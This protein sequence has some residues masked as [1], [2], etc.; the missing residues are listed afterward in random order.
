MTNSL[1]IAN[2]N[3]VSRNKIAM[4]RIKVIN[5]A[6]WKLNLLN[7]IKKSIMCTF[8]IDCL[9]NNWLN[10][11]IVYK[12]HYVWLYRKQPSFSLIWVGKNWLTSSNRVYIIS[13]R[14][15]WKMKNWTSFFFLFT[16]LLF[17]KMKSFR[18]TFNLTLGVLFFLKS[19]SFKQ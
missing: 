5:N 18:M 11:V 16:I 8:S 6:F 15:T 3:K 12:C 17:F 7:K 10:R 1:N 2:Y 19:F 4:K 13:R 14:Y 9:F